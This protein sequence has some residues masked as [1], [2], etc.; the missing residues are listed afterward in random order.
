MKDVCYMC[1]SVEEV[2]LWE[3]PI[4]REKYPVCSFCRSMIIGVCA[5][6]NEIIHRSEHFAFIGEDKILCDKCTFYSELNE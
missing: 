6:C 4:T 2:S 1:G 3:H 5:N